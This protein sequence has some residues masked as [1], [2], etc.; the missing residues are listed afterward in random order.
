MFRVSSSEFKVRRG[1]V[2]PLSFA[3]SL[4][5]SNHETSLDDR[6]LPHCSTFTNIQFALVHIR[7]VYDFHIASRQ[8]EML[9]GLRAGTN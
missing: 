9:G 2:A 6:L 7:S 5:A 3:Y 1:L 4:E 8:I